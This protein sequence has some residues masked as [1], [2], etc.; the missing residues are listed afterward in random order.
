MF[1][2]NLT[3]GLLME[4][5]LFAESGFDTTEQGVQTREDVESGFQKVKDTTEQGS[6]LLG[7]LNYLVEN[8]QLV[9]EG[10]T[11][12]LKVSVDAL[13]VKPVLQTM[14]CIGANCG[15]AVSEML[16]IISLLIQL[17]YVIGAVQLVSGRPLPGMQ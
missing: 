16:N 15:A 5:G 8:V 17:T 14:F 13:L 2:L 7:S 3:A 6:G 12:F 9:I 10:I 11:I 4:I 1:T